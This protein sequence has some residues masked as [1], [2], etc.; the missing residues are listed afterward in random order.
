MLYREAFERIC[1]NSTPTSRTDSSVPLRM[2]GGLVEDNGAEGPARVA[3]L[4]RSARLVLDDCKEHA[5]STLQA[6]RDH[7]GTLLE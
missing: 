2:L 7:N 5:G 3:M 4:A 1:L 6:P